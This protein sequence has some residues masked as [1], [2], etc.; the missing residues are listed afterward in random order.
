MVNKKRKTLRNLLYT[1]PITA[2]SLLPGCK[3][4]YIKEDTIPPKINIISPFKGEIFYNTPTILIQW[5]IQDKIDLKDTW[6]SV[7]NGEKFHMYSKSGSLNWCIKGGDNKVVIGAEDIYSNASKDS[8][9]SYV[10]LDLIK[11]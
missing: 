10:W 4:E 6:I 8:T 7:N 9:N 11:K 1:I 5:D 2:V 3:K